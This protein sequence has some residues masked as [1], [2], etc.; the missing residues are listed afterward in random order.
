M[1]V[2]AG[3]CWHPVDGGGWGDLKTM[4]SQTRGILGLWTVNEAC[5]GPSV[6]S[7]AIPGGR[8]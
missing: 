2:S 7:N 5:H 4:M 8:G 6:R 1:A 3:P